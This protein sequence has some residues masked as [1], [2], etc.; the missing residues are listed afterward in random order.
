MAVFC[1]PVLLLHEDWLPRQSTRPKENLSSKAGGKTKDLQRKILSFVLLLRSKQGL[2]CQ[3]AHLCLWVAY[4]SHP[5]PTFAGA[6]IFHQH[7]IM[8]S[9]EKREKKKEQKIVCLPNT[10]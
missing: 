8:P 2:C 6:D 1:H 7:V 10:P 9:S 3:V 5:N 4:T